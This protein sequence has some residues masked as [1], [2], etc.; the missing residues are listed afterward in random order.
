M[1]RF[2]FWIGDINISHI[3]S[4]A[5]RVLKTLNVLHRIKTERIQQ[6]FVISRQINSATHVCDI[7]KAGV[8]YIYKGAKIA[9]SLYNKKTNKYGLNLSLTT[10]TQGTRKM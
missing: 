3:P 4:L 10:T 9:E 1:V 8:V 2:G 6:D 5:R 7:E